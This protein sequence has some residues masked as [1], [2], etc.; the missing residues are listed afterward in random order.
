MKKGLVYIFIMLFSFMCIKMW[1]VAAVDTGNL[2]IAVDGFNSVS[3]YSY[4]FDVKLEKDGKPVTGTFNV[5]SD[6]NLNKDYITLDEEGEATIVVTGGADFNITIL[7]VPYGTSY[8]VNASTRSTYSSMLPS[9]II[10]KLSDTTGTISNSV[11]IV[12]FDIKCKWVEYVVKYEDLPATVDYDMPEITINTVFHA[13]YTEKPESIKYYGAVSGTMEKTGDGRDFETTF[14]IKKGEQVT[15]YV[16][17]G[18]Q[19]FTTGYIASD[20]MNLFKKYYN[21]GVQVQVPV[22]SSGIMTVEKPVYSYL[23]MPN[24]SASLSIEKKTNGKGIEPN[25]KYRFKISMESPNLDGSYR[26]INGNYFYRILDTVTSEV[27]DRGKIKFNDGVAYTE[28]KDKQKIIIDAGRDD[29]ETTDIYSGHHYVAKGI[30]SN[31]LPEHSKYAVEEVDDDG[32]IV[33]SSE[34]S[35]IV[36]GDTKVEFINERNFNGKLTLSKQIKGDISNEEEFTF[37]IKLNDSATDIPTEYRYTG[38]K[39]GIIKFKDGIGSIT[40]NGGENITI[41]GLPVGSSYE[42]TENNSKYKVTSE[43]NV[44]KVSEETKVVFTNTKEKR[45]DNPNTIDNIFKCIVT[46][47]ISLIFIILIGF[48]CLKRRLIN[49]E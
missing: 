21:I 24:S 16:P 44:G 19:L 2:I 29:F 4:C 18:T 33:S 26:K 27:I 6:G 22:T 34:S 36:K 25:K 23:V 46:G 3:S 20:A 12:K 32:Y 35:G 41:E 1:T 43:N 11:S 28:L 31:F 37:D 39:E 42:V 17:Y 45:I 7:D 38:S 9:S 30:I 15:F 5:N 47:I 8:S 13:Y 10:K 14:T 49:I 40:L 48:K